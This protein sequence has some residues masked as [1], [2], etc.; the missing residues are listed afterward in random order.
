M[1][2][3]AEVTARDLLTI[4]AED[5]GDKKSDRTLWPFEVVRDEGGKPQAVRRQ[6]GDVDP[7]RRFVIAF[8]SYDAQSGGRRLMKLREILQR[9]EAKLRTTSL[10]TRG[11]LIE[12]LLDRGTI[13]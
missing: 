8:N 1:L 13:G 10:D 9:P 7:D 6:G 5:A 2:A 3:T 12:G 4:V 11:A